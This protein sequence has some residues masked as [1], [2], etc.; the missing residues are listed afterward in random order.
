MNRS[1]VI[2]GLSD[3]R[4]IVEDYLG[5]YHKDEDKLIYLEDVIREAQRAVMLNEMND[6][7]AKL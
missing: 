1:E 6:P 5:V 4:R 3:V 2:A 7:Y